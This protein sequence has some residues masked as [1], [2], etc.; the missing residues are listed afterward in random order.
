MVMEYSEVNL[1]LLGIDRLG[2]RPFHAAYMEPFDLIFFTNGSQVLI[3]QNLGVFRGM[4]IYHSSQLQSVTDEI[5]RIRIQEKL[6][7]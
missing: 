2:Y 7:L 5:S 3:L 1:F 6:G 4:R